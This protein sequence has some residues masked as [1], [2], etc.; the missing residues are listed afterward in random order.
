M[1]STVLW[2]EQHITFDIPPSEKA[3]QVKVIFK[4]HKSARQ[5]QLV[6]DAPDRIKIIRP[7]NKTNLES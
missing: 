7:K 4:K 6:I 2:E 3:Q 1:L 5:A